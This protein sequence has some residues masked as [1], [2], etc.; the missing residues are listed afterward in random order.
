MPELRKDPIAR[1]WVII[2]TERAARPTD[3]RHEVLEDNDLDQCP[4]EE[5]REVLTPP[6]IFVVRS[7]GTAPNGPGWRVRVVSNKYP[8]LRVEGTT[9]RTRVGIFTQMGGVGAHEVI[10]ETTD[11]R[12]HLGMLP[13]DH[14]ADVIR[15]Y[16]HRYRDLRNDDRFEYVLLFRNHGRTAGASLSHPHSQLIA[17]PVVPKR[18]AEELDSAE[19]YFGRQ[20]TCIYC[21]MLDQ[22]REAGARL[23][24]ENEK[25]TVLEPYASRFPFETWILPKVHQA[26]FGALAPGAEGQLAQA[27]QETLQRLHVCLANPPYNIIIHT[28]PYKAESRHAYHWHIEIMPRLTQ[29]AGFEWGSGFYI[30]P[31]V[32]EDAARYLRDARRDVEAILPRAGGVRVHGEVGD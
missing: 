5:G 19:R 2:S 29:V 22:E 8:A 13:V 6:E 1:R 3:F 26:D 25:F 20:G 15:A 27:L 17:L 10:I 23:V 4:F 7:S 16:L 11:H 31:V 24:F 32:P 28:L 30:N 9:D 14:V 21:A 12:S 18:V